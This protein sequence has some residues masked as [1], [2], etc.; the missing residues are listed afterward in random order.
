MDSFYDVDVD[1]D[2]ELDD[3]FTKD[4]LDGEVR[5][6]S[7]K[8]TVPVMSIFEKSKIISCRCHQ[9]NKGY[10]TNIPDEVKSKNLVSSFDISMEEF[11]LNKLP[12]YVLKRVYP[13]GR[14]ELWKH[15]DFKYFPDIVS[16]KFSA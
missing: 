3:E 7:E 15:E 4:D 6:I 8:R 1:M 2:D 16:Q 5:M 11:R 14:Y 13:D 9:L 12:P 10:K